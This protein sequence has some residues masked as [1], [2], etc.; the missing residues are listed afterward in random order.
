LL[1]SVAYTHSAACSLCCTGETAEQ[2]ANKTAVAYFRRHPDSFT[3]DDTIFQCMTHYCT[4]KK[5]AAVYSRVIP[6]SPFPLPSEP[7]VSFYRFAC[8]V[9]LCCCFGVHSASYRNGHQN[10]KNK[11]SGE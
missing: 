8:T 4:L 11:V 10:Q 3:D 2:K 1:R 7:R 6:Q 5:E 9:L